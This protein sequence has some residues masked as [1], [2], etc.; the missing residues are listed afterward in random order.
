M[1]ASISASLAISKRGALLPQISALLFN[2]DMPTVK[3][4]R[5]ANLLTLIKREGS[6]ASFAR[7]TQTEPIYIRQLKDQA[8]DSKTGRPRSMGE[9]TVEKIENAY[10]LEPGAMDRPLVGML[11]VLNDRNA[12]S[13]IGSVGS[14][15]LSDVGA[16]RVVA[17]LSNLNPQKRA[18][19]LEMLEGAAAHTSHLPAK[20]SQPRPD[21]MGVK[22]NVEKSQ[23]GRSDAVPGVANSGKSR[24]R[25]SA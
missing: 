17:L 24:H 13:A 7:K 16:A 12:A 2:H 22:I 5:F 4:I 1:Q 21:L 3:E 20:S 19:F 25:K 6:V 18:F 10:A 14:P 11:E 15:S 9:K 8:P 23:H